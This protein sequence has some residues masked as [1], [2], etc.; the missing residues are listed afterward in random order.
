MS[1]DHGHDD[2]AAQSERV[3]LDEETTAAEV[4]MRSMDNRSKNVMRR[5][6]TTS[7][8][9]LREDSTETEGELAQ[10][11]AVSCTTAKTKR[12]V[13]DRLRRHGTCESRH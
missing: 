1:H 7:A 10:L 5:S 9:G 8:R 2:R 11:S 6:E 4:H 12:R 13:I 3:C